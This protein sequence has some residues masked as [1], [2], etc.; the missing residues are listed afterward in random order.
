MMSRASARFLATS[1]PYPGKVSSTSGGI[2]Q[3][4]AGGGI[5]APPIAP[6][7]SL[8]MSMKARR[9]RVSTIARRSSGLSK[10]GLLRL[11]SI[12]R[13]MFH[14][15]IVH[16]ALGAWSLSCFI[17]GSDMMPCPVRSN[18]PA[19]KARIVVAGLGINL[20]SIASR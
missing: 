20:Y 12:C 3:L 14:G 10:S 1:E 5:I 11:T 2:P 16:S 17:S 8:R 7:P 13:G 15:T 6:C 19:P 18:L 9:S 4:P